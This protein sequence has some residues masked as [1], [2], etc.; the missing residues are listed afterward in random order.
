VGN[1]GGNLRRTFELTPLEA[2]IVAAVRS[3]KR[4]QRWGEI[5]IKFRGGRFTMS[6]SSSTMTPDEFLKKYLDTEEPN[7]RGTEATNQRTDTG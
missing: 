2:A 1:Q 3:Y 7:E 4:G 6:A 5:T